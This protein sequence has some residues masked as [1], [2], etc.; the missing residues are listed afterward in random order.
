M[1]ILWKLLSIEYIAKYTVTYVL[2]PNFFSQNVLLTT[3]YKS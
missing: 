2:I 3:Y 1:L